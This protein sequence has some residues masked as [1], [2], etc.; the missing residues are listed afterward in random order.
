MKSSI[1]VTLSVCLT[2][3][4]TSA[5]AQTKQWVKYEPN[6]TLVYDT[7][8]DG[9]R[10]P[11]FSRSGYRQGSPVPV[12]S[13]G[14]V[15]SARVK[16]VVPTGAP[17]V[18]RANIQA[19]LDDLADDLP[20]IIQ[21][22][23][24]K[25][26][27]IVILDDPNVTTG[28]VVFRIDQPL[29][30]RA[31]GIILRGMGTALETKRTVLRGE[32]ENCNPI[33]VVQ[34]GIYD[35]PNPPYPDVESR[36]EVGT[37]RNVAPVDYPTGS[38]E[39]D[40]R[41]AD[42]VFEY[43]DEVLVHRIAHD[44]TYPGTTDPLPSKWIQA[45]DNS[46]HNSQSGWTSSSPT[47]WELEGGPPDNT[48]GSYDHYWTRTVLD[49]VA[50][51][52]GHRLVLDAPIFAP[53]DPNF[54][55]ANVSRFIADHM[56]NTVG[57]EDLVLESRKANGSIPTGTDTAH[58][59]NGV[60]FGAARNCWMRAVHGLYF[61]YTL[62]TTQRDTQ[63]ITILGCRA[64]E[65]V[66]P[67]EGGHRYPYN[68]LGQDHLVYR[69]LARKARHAFVTQGNFNDNKDGPSTGI[70]FVEC[71]ARN[72]YSDVGPHSYGAAGNLWD[73]VLMKNPHVDSLKFD[74]WAF[75][76]G[77]QGFDGHGWAGLSSVAWNC[78]CVDVDPQTQAETPKGR[79]VVEFPNGFSGSTPLKGW[80][81]WAIGCL[82]QH[83]TGNAFDFWQT[84]YVVTHPVH[85]VSFKS[86]YRLQ[87]YERL[88]YVWLPDLYLNDF[89]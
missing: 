53:L 86:L 35:G 58:P 26:R 85:G 38:T 21:N 67:I 55:R 45:L 29:R 15:P 57:I 62:V 25:L 10:I 80:R 17:A 71:V 31:S 27:G 8:G 24:V 65:P 60:S 1:P 30:I 43:G 40:V 69:C 4:A 44:G 37:T 12:V 3:L 83:K 33:I 14:D 89:N 7:D 54:G 20:L 13:V 5:A 46:P 42:G 18:D 6:G 19:A 73:N 23:G 77:F 61:D 59:A 50:S 87:L 9:A 75:I 56:V 48:L 63:W 16:L 28:E 52:N 66:G 76:V 49:V 32:G 72:M 64:E 74:Q 78:R 82:A 84:P 36:R 2:L 34:D 68:I 81:S 47:G 22:G 79:F 41:N 39:L 70:A 51:P 88:G 11:D